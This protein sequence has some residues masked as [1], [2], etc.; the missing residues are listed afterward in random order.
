M[1]IVNSG[2]F[3]G[4]SNVP[5]NESYSNL[6]KAVNFVLPLFHPFRFIA[7]FWRQKII[8]FLFWFHN[9]IIF[10]C[11]QNWQHLLIQAIFFYCLNVPSKTKFSL[12]WRQILMYC[13]FGD[14]IKNLLWCQCYVISVPDC[15]KISGVA[16]LNYG[17]APAIKMI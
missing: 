11:F 4:F 17:Y 12:I 14:K 9:M 5:F 15:H 8:T 2:C 1:H 16:I 10:Y 6:L 7:K 3:N 13:Q